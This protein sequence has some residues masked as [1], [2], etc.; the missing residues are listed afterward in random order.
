MRLLRSIFVESLSIMILQ[1]K[2]ETGNIQV[3]VFPRCYPLVTL[4]T[5]SLP[6]CYL[7]VSLVTS[8]YMLSLDSTQ[9][10]LVLDMVSD[11]IFG[12]SLSL[13]S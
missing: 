4:V 5:V 9:I 11:L 1:L 13:G 3:T 7:A 10:V 12:P 8:C 6:R 2:N